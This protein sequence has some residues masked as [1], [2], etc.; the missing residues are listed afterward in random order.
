[1]SEIATT[2][3]EYPSNGDTGMG[4][5]ARPKTGSGPGVVVIQEWWGL[6]AHIKNVTERFARAGYVA[7]AP[8]LYRGKSASEP[9]EARKLAMELE[10]D[11]AVMDI[12]GAAHYLRSLP[13][14]SPKKVGVVG[15][16]M[17]GGLAFAVAH[18]TNDFSAAV[19]FYG[20]PP[21]DEETARI[22]CPV[23]GLFGEK[24]GGIP[25]QVAEAFRASLAKHSKTHA[26]HVYPGAPHAFF[27][28]SRPHIYKADAAQDAW[29]RT[30]D[31]FAQHLS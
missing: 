24:D 10:R 31:W 6:E 29:R 16:C 15:W 21:G 12:A 25:P 8:D 9:D 1:M 19:G 17:G 18:A 22:N 4:Y 13:E 28:D 23:M 2:S 7:L 27:N 5:L 30:L 3:I 20:R 11:R 14:V 26:V